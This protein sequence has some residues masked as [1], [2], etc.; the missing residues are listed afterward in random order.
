MKE[1]HNPPRTHADDVHNSELVQ[2]V[3]NTY[4]VAGCDTDLMGS[5]TGQV[6]KSP[7]RQHGA[8]DSIDR[9]EVPAQDADDL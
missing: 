7:E 6:K 5:Y 3:V 9:D 1:K 8:V 2:D 4:A